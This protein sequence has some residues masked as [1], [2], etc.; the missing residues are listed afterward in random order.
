VGRVWP[1][2]RHRGRP[3]NSVVRH[4]MHPVRVF[5]VVLL[6]FVLPSSSLG[7]APDAARPVDQ[8]VESL[9]QNIASTNADPAWRPSPEQRTAIE[10]ITKAYF[11]AR[12]SNK[13]DDAY[14]FLSPRLKQYQPLGVFQRRIEEFNAKA[15]PVQ[16]RRLR[17]ITWYK[18]TPQAGPGLYAAVDY[19]SEF[20]NLA[21]HCGYV[22]WH[23]QPDG[24]FLQVREEENVIDNATMAKLGPSAL[25]KVRAQFRC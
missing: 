2:H 19:S 10:A 23:E 18:D 11:S 13:S 8:A 25:A 12:D 4:R 21:L 15:G 24:K 1:R 22:V 7:Q 6:W 20:Q 5:S 17:A 3:L 16:V 14:A 9:R